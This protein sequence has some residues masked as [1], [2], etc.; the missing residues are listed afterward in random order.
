MDAACSSNYNSNDY[1][2]RYSS[3]E[4]FRRRTCSIGQCTLHMVPVLPGMKT[5]VYLN[6][7]PDTAHVSLQLDFD[8]LQMP[9]SVARA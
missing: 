1:C 8:L 3:W 9:D 4:V 6:L 2:A 7:L 5:T